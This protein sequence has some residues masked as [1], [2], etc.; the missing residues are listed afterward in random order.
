MH[1]FK[2]F[3]GLV[4]VRTVPMQTQKVRRVSLDASHEVVDPIDAIRIAGARRADELVT[5]LLAK[6]YDLLEPEV[7][8][9]LRRDVGSFGFVEVMDDGVARA[10]DAIP[11]VTGEFGQIVDHGTEWSAA[12]QLG[13]CPGVPVADGFHGT[14]EVDFVHFF[15]DSLM[16]RTVGVGPVPEEASLFDDHLGRY[17]R[18]ELIFDG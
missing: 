9:L 7:R 3:D 12:F 5:V 10:V 11:V 8:G 4:V 14:G 13:R 1:A 2:V 18:S 17:L 15:W 16:S 6:R